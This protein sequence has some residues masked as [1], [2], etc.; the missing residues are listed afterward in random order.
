MNSYDSHRIK[1]YTVAA[2]KAYHPDGYI[3]SIWIDGI[4]AAEDWTRGSYD[5]CHDA[6]KKHAVRLMNCRDMEARQ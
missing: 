1:V 2:P 3:S 6:A 5:R 4:L